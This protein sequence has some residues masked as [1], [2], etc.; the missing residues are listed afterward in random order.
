MSADDLQR[1]LDLYQ[2]RCAPC[3][4]TNGAGDGPQGLP[5]D[6]RPRNYTDPSWQKSISDQK[7]A[8]T[9]IRGGAEV[10]LSPTMPP[11]PDLKRKP[12]IVNGLV[13]II[14]GFAD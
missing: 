8:D 6:P 11:N 12:K 3:H 5:L 4:G 10:S 7:I 1:A 2:T 13:E 14:R 9:I